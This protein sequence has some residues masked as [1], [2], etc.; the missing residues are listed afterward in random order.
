M[1]T[2]RDL[3]EAKGKWTK[4]VACN[5]WGYHYL[6]YKGTDVSGPFKTYDRDAELDVIAGDRIRIHWPDG[7]EQTVMIEAKPYYEVVHDMGHEYPTRGNDMV[8]YVMHN[9]CKLC[10]PLEQLEVRCDAFK[11]VKRDEEP[12]YRHRALK[13]C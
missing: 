6:A 10:V 12:V 1:K 11:R 7:S 4:L 9:G 8:V 3:T 5:N 13:F 2:G